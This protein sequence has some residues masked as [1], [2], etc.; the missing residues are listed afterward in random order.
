MKCKVFIVLAIVCAIWLGWF[1]RGFLAIDR[2]LDQGGR[3][4]SRGDY[5]DGAKSAGG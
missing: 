3:W 4:E 5:C 1:S 2:C